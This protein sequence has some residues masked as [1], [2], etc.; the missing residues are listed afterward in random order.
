M[1]QGKA[2][3]SEPRRTQHGNLAVDIEIDGKPMLDA[4]YRQDPEAD[5]DDRWF[6]QDGA[7]LGEAAGGTWDTLEEAMT[8]VAKAVTPAG[9]R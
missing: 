2:R 4:I 3:F 7:D 1:R 8:A 5:G 9:A 6:L